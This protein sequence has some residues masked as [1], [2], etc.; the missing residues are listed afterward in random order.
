MKMRVSLWIL[1]SCITKRKLGGKTCKKCKKIQKMSLGKNTN[2]ATCMTPSQTPCFPAGWMDASA[3]S[4]FFKEDMS[5]VWRAPY[6][7][8]EASRLMLRG[9]TGNL[10]RAGGSA[11]GTGA[12]LPVRRRNEVAGDGTHEPHHWGR[13]AHESTTLHRCISD[14]D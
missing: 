11:L 10:G 6:T 1:I 5:I 8:P 7:P 9:R 12:W 14:P 4:F 3:E 2:N 13:I